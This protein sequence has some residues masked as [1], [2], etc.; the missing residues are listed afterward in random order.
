VNRRLLGANLTLLIV[1]LL[2]LEVPLGLLYGRQQHRALDTAL[3]RDATA[4]AA[5]GAQLLDDRGGGLLADVAAPGELVAVIGPTGTVSTAEDRLAGARFDEV[6]RHARDEGPTRG[7]TADLVYVAKPFPAHAGLAGAALVARP[8]AAID[9]RAR[10]FWA[11]LGVAGAAVV[12]ISAVLTTRTSR[13]ISRPLRRLDEQAAAFGRGDLDARL[14]IDGAPPEVDALAAT[15]NRMASQLAGVVRAQRRFVADAS[16]QLRT[17]LTAVRLRLE[18]LGPERPMEVSAA[19]DAALD[20]LARLSYLVDGLLLL[21]R[22]EGAAPVVVDVD[23]AAALRD[24]Q[25]AWAPLADER[26]VAM[27]VDAPQRASARVAEGH[28]EQILDN[29]VDNALEATPAGGTVELSAALVDG[30]VEVHVRDDGAGMSVDE[31]RHAFV[32]FWRGRGAGSSGTG[33]G[34]AIVDQLARAS[35]GTAALRSSTGGGVD[36][37]IRLPASP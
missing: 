37:V 31:L 29:L 9:G 10:R 30:A 6:L 16:H 18:N 17:P 20:E 3:D 12:A 28:L 8:D 35:G 5:V 15:F 1:L 26:G 33:L 19:R 23:V 27:L 11:V 22:A 14:R 4:L 24:R 7:E 21:A 13:W 36:A 34:V 2:T 32:P 25:Q